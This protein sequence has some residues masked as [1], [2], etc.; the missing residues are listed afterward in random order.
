MPFDGLFLHGICKELNE[1]LSQGRIEKIYQPIREEIVLIVSKPGNKYRLLL[2]AN[3]IDAR[4][5]LTSAIRSNPTSPPMFCMLLRK[6]LEGGR[7]T[8]FFQPGLDRVLDIRVDTRDETGQPEQ[9]SLFCEIMGR[10]SNIILVSCAE[11]TIIDGIRRYT[12]AVSRHREVLPGRKYIPPPGQAKANPFNLLE[13]DFRKL[14]LESDLDEPLAVS[15]QKKLDGL[16][17]PTC[18]RIVELAGLPADLILDH[19]GEYELRALWQSLQKVLKLSTCGENKTT[20]VYNQQGQPIEFF[21]IPIKPKDNEQYTYQA[22][23]DTA[24]KFFSD[25]V[26]REELRKQK[27]LILERIKK[28]NKRLSKKLKLQQKSVL[29]A[30]EGNLYRLYGELLTANL[31]RVGRGLKE[32]ELENYHD[33]ELK[34]ITIP[35]IPERTGSENAQYYFKKYNKARNTIVA[36]QKMA[37]LTSEELQYL[38]GVATAVEMADNGEELDEVRQELVTQGYLKNPASVQGRKQSK[39]KLPK[40]KPLEFT[41]SDGMTILVG[42]NNRQNDTLTLK[43]A[44]DTDIWLHTSKIPGSHVIIRTGGRAV[45]DHTLLEAAALAAYYSRARES[46]N[47]PVDYTLCRYVK[48]PNGAKPGYVVYEKQKTIFVDPKIPGQTC[49]S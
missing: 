38:E 33:P 6:H 19:C 10:H 36:A 18:R 43:T 5:H 14:V 27:T 32:V 35:L 28:E 1:K 13:D 46:S 47:V 42:K 39:A 29:N 44:E 34:R 31:Y 26:S 21:P 48:K 22:A 45:P 20:L 12:H 15:I 41:S 2:S 25:K 11:N 23:N 49:L 3:A 7:I 24:D 37:N 8:G 16:S 9:K 17:I 40:L 30:E 4:V